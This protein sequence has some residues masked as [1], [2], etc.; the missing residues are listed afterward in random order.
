MKTIGR[1]LSVFWQAIRS[2][3]LLFAVYTYMLG[4]F[5]VVFLYLKY[6]PCKYDEDCKQQGEVHPF[7]LAM[8]T[9]TSTYFM[10]VCRSFVQ[11]WLFGK[12]S[13]LLIFTRLELFTIFTL[14]NTFCVLGWDV[15]PR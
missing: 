5:G 13:I 2:A 15:W 3:S 11:I 1:F 9:F 12:D 8:T 6:F 4:A 10:T 14:S 7:V